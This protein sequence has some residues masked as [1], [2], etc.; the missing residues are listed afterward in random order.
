MG[1][2]WAVEEPMAYGSSV[3]GSGLVEGLRVSDSVDG[4]SMPTTT[5]ED[6][7]LRCPR[8]LDGLD[9]MCA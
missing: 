1:D 2:E 7:L 9:G 4:L 6:C 5:F 8:L 3:N